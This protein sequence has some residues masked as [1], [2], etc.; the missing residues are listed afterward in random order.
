MRM[1]VKTLLI[2]FLTFSFITSTIGFAQAVDQRKISLS[3]LIEEALRENPRLKAAY[4][5]WQASL[6]KIP[7]AKSLP[8]PVL[9]YA[10]FGQSIETRLGPQRNKLSLSQKIPFFGKLSLKGKIAERGASVQE[11]EFNRIKA[12]IILKVKMSFFSLYW[13]DKVIRITQEEKEVLQR[14]ARIARK[15]YEAGQVSQQDVLK[16]MLEIS[17]VEEKILILKQRRKAVAAELNSL[18]NR[19]EDSFLGEVEELEMA[20]LGIDLKRLYSIAEKKRP[21][22]KKAEQL[23]EKNRESLKLAKKN[24]YP[25]FTLRVD[26]IDI[27]GGTTS[28]QF[29]D[30]LSRYKYSHLEK[31]TQGS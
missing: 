31:Q 20:P 2:I 12:E 10:H 3:E 15:K 23:I 22:L 4:S 5:E 7:Q 11:A 8:D 24:Y 16:A 13:L 9:G 28:P 21:E 26:Y 19:A 17:R 6:E 27:G 29:L 25:D 1:K 14:L 18:L 30:G